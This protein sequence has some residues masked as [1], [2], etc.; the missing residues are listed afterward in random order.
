MNTPIPAPALGPLGGLLLKLISCI[1]IFTWAWW[2]WLLEAQGQVMVSSRVWDTWL[3][4]FFL[5]ADPNPQTSFWR[6][7]Y[8]D[9]IF[10]ATLAYD[11]CCL[12]KFQL[13][14]IDEANTTTTIKWSQKH[15]KLHL[16]LLC[17]SIGQ[18]RRAEKGSRWEANW[19]TRGLDGVHI[20]RSSEES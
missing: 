14:G 20:H 8:R 4:Q 5:R 15:K 6:Q 2:W 19:Y 12:V 9:A 18:R 11:I 17:D 13:F 1:S 3:H 16:I 7:E 10:P